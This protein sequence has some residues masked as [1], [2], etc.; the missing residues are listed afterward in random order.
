MRA[1]TITV[2]ITRGGD[3][4]LWHYR[5]QSAVHTGTRKANRAILD[6]GVQVEEARTYIEELVRAIDSC[7]EWR[8][9]HEK[10]N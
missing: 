8:A 7:H 1:R 5:M 9:R 3:Y 10:R 4:A 2:D 6:F